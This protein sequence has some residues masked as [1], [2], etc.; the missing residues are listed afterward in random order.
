MTKGNFYAALARFPA[1]MDDVRASR[2]LKSFDNIF[3]AGRIDFK[4]LPKIYP[5]INF[6]APSMVDDIL[7]CLLFIIKVFPPP[8]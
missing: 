1:I 2:S 8:P 3:K 4:E 6:H 7:T 5:L